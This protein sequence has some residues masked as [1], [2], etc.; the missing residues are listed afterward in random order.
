MR[1]RKVILF[2]GIMV[3]LSACFPDPLPIDGIPQLDSKIVVSTQIDGDQTVLLLL[4]KSVG[5]LDASDDSDLEALLN[6]I[7]INDAVVIIS[8]NEFSDTLDFIDSGLY[9]SAAIPLE[10]GVEYSLEV[11]SPTMGTVTSSTFLK[12]RVSFEY[13][14]ARLYNDGY[15]TL[16]EVI[17]GFNDPAE[18]NFYMFNVQR[19]TQEYEAEDLLNPEIF[20]QLIDD[21]TFETSSYSD[22]QQV[23]ASRD[24]MPGDTIAI[25]LSNISEEYY[26]FMQLRLDSRF[27][28]AEYL[29]EPA[30]YPSNINGGLGFFNLYIPDVRI[31]ELQ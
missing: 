4:T 6:E 8:T 25:F 17:Y 18:K 26:D 9:I 22:S 27:S 15:D 10:A 24:F 23:S 14:E 2:F 12:P 16:A 21:E 3:L 20:T 28:F 30:N 29:A 19:L 7:A 13:V 5:A 31:A 11:K 1:I